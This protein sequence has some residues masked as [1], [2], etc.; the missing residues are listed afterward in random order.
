MIEKTDGL[1]PGLYKKIDEEIYHGMAGCSQ[2]RLKTILNWSPAHLAYAIENP[3]EDTT[4]AKYLGTAIHKALLEPD[5]FNQTYA[6]AGPCAGTTAKGQPCGN[7][8]KVRS[9]GLWF[10]GKHPPEYADDI[11][12]LNQA[13][14]DACVGIRDKAYSRTRSRALLECGSRKELTAVWTDEETGIVCRARYD[15]LS[16]DGYIIGDLKSTQSAEDRAFS[17]SIYKFGYYIQASFYLWGARVL[18]VPSDIFAI[19]AVEKKPPYEC[20]VFEVHGEVIEAGE[21]EMRPLLRRYAECLEKNEW[22]GY[23][24]KAIPVS[25]PP[26]SWKQIEA[27]AFEAEV[28]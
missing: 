6:V 10:C 7:T 18:G 19:L 24:D 12:Q 21:K 27:R 11:L 9:G 13:Q 28:E 3:G 5:L 4:E 15:I 2:S 22:P 26:W 20:Q 1:E 23:P 16:D 17:N 8:G 25:L 14:W